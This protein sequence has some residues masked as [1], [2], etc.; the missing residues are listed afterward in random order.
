MSIAPRRPNSSTALAKVAESTFLSCSIWRPKR[1]TSA[2]WSSTPVSARLFACS[3]AQRSESSILAACLTCKVAD[4]DTEVFFRHRAA[5]HRPKGASYETPSCPRG[6]RRLRLLSSRASA[7]GGSD[8]RLGKAQA[9]NPG[10]LSRPGQDRHHGGPRN[11][12]GRLPEEDSGGGRHP[13]QGLCLGSLPRQPR[14]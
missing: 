4:R 12:G 1:I 8:R 5:R 11:P 2:S 10:A 9:R 6:R 7:H 13:H 3:V 14:R